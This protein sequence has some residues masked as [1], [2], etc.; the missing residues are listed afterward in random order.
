MLGKLTTVWVPVTDMDRAVA[1]YTESLGLTVRDR[2]GD[3]WTEIEG[4]GVTIGLNGRESA[5]GSGESGPGGAVITFSP[6]GSLDD[7]VARLRDAGVT[8]A[9]EISEHAW[10]RLATFRDSEGNDL[11]LYAPPA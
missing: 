3:D 1:F 2:Q 11:Q 6:D 10:G 5:S 4:S 8:F 7:E 9:G